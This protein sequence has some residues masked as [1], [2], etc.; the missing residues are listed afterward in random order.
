[1]LLLL[2]FG[3]EQDMSFSVF[4]NNEDGHDAYREIVGKLILRGVAQ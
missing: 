3:D 4:H 2:Q 1:M